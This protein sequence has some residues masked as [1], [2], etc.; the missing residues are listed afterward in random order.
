MKR[1]GIGDL[2]NFH[3]GLT[4]RQIVE[5]SLKFMTPEWKEAFRFA[6][7]TADRLGLEM[8]FASSPGWSESGGPWVLPKDAMKK[9][10]WSETRLTG[11]KRFHGRL[12]SPPTVTGLYQGF[13]ASNQS[14]A[15][16]ADVL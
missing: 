9:L 4:T 11:G 6:A 13:A 7:S 5:K 15:Y 12:S 3:V 16:Y 10:V 2:Q 14:V 8:A 1:V